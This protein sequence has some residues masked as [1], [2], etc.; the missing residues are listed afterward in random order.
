MNIN[1]VMKKN[2]L[3][4]LEMQRPQL[5]YFKCHPDA[6]SLRFDTGISLVLMSTSWA[7]DKEIS[8][9]SPRDSTKE[10]ILCDELTLQYGQSYF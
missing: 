4:G 9:Y 6:P 5:K 8:V 3:R 7:K 2:G 10:N 1:I